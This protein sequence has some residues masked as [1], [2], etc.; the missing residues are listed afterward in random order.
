MKLCK[1]HEPWWLKLG[2]KKYRKLFWPVKGRTSVATRYLRCCQQNRLVLDPLLT[3]I[4]IWL[5]VE[6]LN[7]GIQ[8]HG[9]TKQKWEGHQLMMAHAHCWQR[10]W[11]WRWRQN[12][13]S[14]DAHWQAQIAWLCTAR[15]RLGTFRSWRESKK[16]LTRCAICVNRN[17]YLRACEECVSGSP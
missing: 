7:R 2:K 17:P 16:E 12:L 14:S 11:G 10:C 15:W 6:N 5:L 8:M 3:R 1:C 4:V 9:W 13:L